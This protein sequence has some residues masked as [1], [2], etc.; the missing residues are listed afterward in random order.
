MFQKCS[1]NVTR[2]HFKVRNKQVYKIYHCNVFTTFYEHQ[3]EMNLKHKKYAFKTF[4]E[5]SLIKSISYYSYLILNIQ[6][7]SSFSLKF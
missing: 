5:I 4:I 7:K 3:I 2:K 1:T 6:E